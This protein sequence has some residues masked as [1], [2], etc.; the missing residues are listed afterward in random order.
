MA[1]SR[2]CAL[3]VTGFPRRD[4]FHRLATFCRHS[5]SRMSSIML[6]ERMS[7]CRC[8]SF[9]SNGSIFL[10]KLFDARIVLTRGNN[11][12]FSSFRSSLSDRSSVSCISFV[13]P[14]F[15]MLGIL[16]PKKVNGKAVERLHH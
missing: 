9:V 8:G 5:M 16:L 10:I 14:R 11:G 1:A 15:S 13:A 3:E 6:L 12:K 7:V 2:Y 4:K